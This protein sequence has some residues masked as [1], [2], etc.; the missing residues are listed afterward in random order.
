VAQ[1]APYF[2]ILLKGALVT[3]GLSAL[4]LVFASLI[5]V[6][7]GMVAMSR[8][9]PGRS[10]AKL[11]V[12]TIRSVP[13]LVQL[14]FVYYAMPLLANV[15]PSPYQAATLSL[16][17]YGGAYMVEAVRSG[18]L[19]VG[20][21]QWMAARSLGIRYRATMLYVVA[22]QALR[23]TIPAAVGIF[24]DML[25][26]A[27]VTSI[28]GFVELMQTAVNIRNTIFALSPLVAAAVLYFVM[29]FSLS[30]VGGGIERIL[31][32]EGR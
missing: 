8:F 31:R 11:Y 2:G 29:C 14:F 27:S 32:Y 21:D 18:I 19:S 15:S 9:A 4:S 25:K 10:F 12:E 1:L 30:K 6:A 26:G 23:V 5:G 3:L 22:P 20:T 24:I 7:I 13:L 28:I 17:V 16:S